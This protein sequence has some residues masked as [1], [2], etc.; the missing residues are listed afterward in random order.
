MAVSQDRAAEIVSLARERG[1]AFAAYHHN[2]KQS[3]IERYIREAQASALPVG[4]S[5]SR[6]LIFTDVHLDHLADEHPAY[7]LVKKFAEDWKPDWIANLGDWMDLSYLSSF[8]KED[9][10]DNERR[11]LGKDV[12][13]ANRELDF[14]HG[15]TPDHTFLQGNHDE[16]LDRM[17]AKMP[18]LEWI[19]SADKL[20]KF[21]ERGVDYY[22]A[23]EQPHKRGKLN[24]IHGWYTNRYHAMKHLDQMSGNIVYGHV[25]VFQTASRTLAAM[26]E[27]IAAWSLGCLCDKA[28]GYLKGRPSSWNHGFAVVYMDELGNFNLYPIRII[29]G[30]FIWEGR[31]YSLRELERRV[32]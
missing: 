29:H 21:K 16:R 15:I 24:M 14:W 26:S 5:V 19:A 6:G 13:L 32:V 9:N 28:P 3:T 20:L 1:V 27:E 30:S 10:L 11:R 17:I 22:P 8:S 18:A 25:H 23:R 12:D 31:R 2:V 7:T 4:S